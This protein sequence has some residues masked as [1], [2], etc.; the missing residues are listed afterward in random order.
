VYVQG[1]YFAVDS[2]MSR[3][4]TTT[5][6]MYMLCVWYTVHWLVLITLLVLVFLFLPDSHIFK[7]IQ[8]TYIIH[9]CNHSCSTC[10]MSHGLL[11]YR[12]EVSY[13]PS[14]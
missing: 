5:L 3:T 14:N 9:S 6:N 4:G 10:T 8:N 12:V 7:S 13:S 2:Y 1:I 11:V